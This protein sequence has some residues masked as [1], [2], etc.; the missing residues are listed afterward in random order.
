MVH[1]PGHD[2]ALTVRVC[3]GD[4]RVH[5]GDAGRHRA[6]GHVGAQRDDGEGVLAEEDQRVHVGLHAGG[7]QH[8]ALVTA[9]VREGGEHGGADE[10]HVFHATQLAFV[11]FAR[12]V[13]GDG[14]EAV[15]VAHVVFHVRVNEGDVSRL[16]RLSVEAWGRAEDLRDFLDVLVLERT[17]GAANQV[18]GDRGVHVGALG[19]VGVQHVGTGLEHVV[20]QHFLGQRGLLAEG[21]GELT[22][23]RR[24]VRVGVHEEVGEAGPL[25]VLGDVHRVVLV[26]HLDAG[27]GFAFG[28][29][30]GADRQVVGT[31]RAAVAT[32]AVLDEVA[33]HLDG[34]GFVLRQRHLLTELLD[35]QQ[36]QRAL[37]EFG[38]GEVGLAGGQIPVGV[39]GVGHGGLPCV[40][41]GLHVSTG[42]ERFGER[43]FGVVRVFGGHYLGAL[44]RRHGGSGREGGLAHRGFRRCLHG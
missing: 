31:G 8:G 28:Q 30:G 33:T 9:G 26:G 25:A 18:Q 14:D 27:L 15:D 36:G 21:V 2:A 11:G 22:D 29:R 10:A 35:G 16:T 44:R 23:D 4:L 42:C 17:D 34:L 7:G 39:A 37:E 12:C 5:H 24:H 6:G 1:R 40:R 43:R 41:G 20:G 3:L 19:A 32:G 13:V 38:D